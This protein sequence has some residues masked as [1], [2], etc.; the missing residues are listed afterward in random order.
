MALAVLGD[1][2]GE[3]AEAPGLGLDDLPAVVGEDFGSVF[4]ERVDLCLGKV[5]TREE[6]MLVK[7]HA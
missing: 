6:N 5:L 4:R 2:V 7:R 3:G 1:P